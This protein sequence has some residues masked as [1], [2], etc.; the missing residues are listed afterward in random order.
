M[1]ASY[2]T[3]LKVFTAR[4]DGEVVYSAH[5]N[6]VQ[7]EIAAIEAILGT[8]PQG[9]SA[10][11]KARIGLLETGKSDT[12]HTHDHGTLTGLGDDDHPQ[13]VLKATGTA[14]GDILAFTGSGAIARRAVGTNGQVPIADSAQATGLNYQTLRDV[15][16]FD[17]TARDALAGGDRWTG[18]VIYNSTTGRHEWWNGSTWTTLG[19][20]GSV[21]SADTFMMMGA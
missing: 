11:V 3:S 2:P 12:G 15:Q 10:T 4:A 1:A 17:T 21:S 18:R 5:M 20:G 8:A 9:G 7:E 16:I 14:K 13:Y 6:E 19:G